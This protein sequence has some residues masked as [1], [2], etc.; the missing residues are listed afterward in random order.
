[1]ESA[2]KN[3]GADGVLPQKDAQLKSLLQVSAVVELSYRKASDN[4][5][6]YIE[7]YVRIEDRDSLEIAVPFT[8][9]DG[10][11]T[12]LKTF[13]EKRLSII[14]KARQLGLSWLALAYASHGLIFKSG[15]Q[16]IALS[17]REEEAKELTRR[18]GF[19]LRHLP[20]W[21]VREKKY[22]PK[23]FTGATWET[24]T[25]TVTIYHPNGE[26]STFISLT[27]SPD[28]GRSFTANLAIID[29]WAFQ[30]WARE[31]WAAAYPTINRPTGG[32]VI[33][34]S[35]AKI[36]TLFEDVWNDAVEGKNDFTP[37]F[38]PWWTDPRR[39]KDWYEKSKTAL[40]DSYLQEYPST[41]EE[42]FSVG[43]LTA[44]PEF[45]VDI[46]VCDD[47]TPPEHWRRWM[48]VDNGYDDPF[49]WYWLAVD[50]NGTV[51]IYR[52]FT[53][54][55]D[56]PKLIYSEQAKRV[57]ELSTYTRIGG[58]GQVVEVQEGCAFRVAGKDAWSTH[59]RD[60][61]GKKLV[62]YYQDGG[63][64]N[65]VPAITDRRL[66]KAVWHEYLKPYWDEVSQ[67]WTARVQICRSCR[68]LIE[69]LPRLPKDEKDPEKV[70]DCS[71]DHW[72]DGAGYGIIAHHA[73]QSGTTKQEIPLEKR[74]IIN[75]INKV[76]R[77]NSRRGRRVS[78]RHVWE[79]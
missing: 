20:G 9:W 51:F 44:F 23:N 40:P 52:E 21:L 11:K 14:L 50:E 70:A 45:S 53:R 12:V 6:F 4:I 10:Q 72:Y 64:A 71:I 38:L 69:T 2:I 5:L 35:T 57:K 49:S 61:T 74:V 39:T 48:A 58:N 26:Q 3:I 68:K 13:E 55:P 24:T 56:E 76:A 33:G 43:E 28:S 1:M 18:I 62:D 47:F 41:P 73:K 36:G 78:K 30:M 54:D 67:T 34:I 75:H 15:Y 66:R 25:S 63:L 17:K 65:F 16:V 32:Q 7:E 37:I 77:T 60:Q 29:E 8:L 22:A 59:H 31:I 46:H 42:A 27:S 19:I 79:G